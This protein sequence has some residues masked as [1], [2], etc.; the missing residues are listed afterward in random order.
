MW[1]TTNGEQSPAN[2]LSFSSFDDYLEFIDELE[3]D[4]GYKVYFSKG[5]LR[6]LQKVSST[7]L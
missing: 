1:Y 2:I 6:I 7:K 3:K 4:T 5:T